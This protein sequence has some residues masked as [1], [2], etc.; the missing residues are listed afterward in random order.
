M[1]HLAKVCVVG[2]IGTG[3]TSLLRRLTAQ[4]FDKNVEPTMG[5]DFFT[6]T[7]RFEDHV[8]KFQFWD[9]SGDERFLSTR[10]AHYLGATLFVLVYDMNNE[11]SFRHLEAWHE[12][13][14]GQSDR[15]LMFVIGGKS[16]LSHMRKVTR[17][18]A[19][20]FAATHNCSYYEASAKSGDGVCAAFDG[21]VQELA[22]NEDG[23]RAEGAASIC[24]MLDFQVSSEYEEEAVEWLEYTSSYRR[25]KCCPCFFN[26]HVEV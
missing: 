6:K 21:I 25:R 5:V 19:E 18:D 22:H 7:F 3:K 12:E 9:G 2:D 24:R 10:S 8:F 26:S 23:A 4:T 20:A 1:T 14:Q 11:D 13:V 16:D 15:S 17:A